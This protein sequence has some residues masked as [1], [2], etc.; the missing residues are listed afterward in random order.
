MPRRAAPRALALAA[1][2]AA[3]ALA[4]PRAADAQAPAPG[5]PPGAGAAPAPGAPPA[6][7]APLVRA[8]QAIPAF[9][10]LRSCLPFN[11]LLAAAAEGGA[12]A[13]D[14]Q[15]QPGGGGGRLI[16]EGDA[17]A[18]NSTRAAVEDG[19][20]TLSLAGGFESR[21]P[22]KI[23]AVMPA[24]AR[25]A[26]A[27]RRCCAPRPR[28]ALRP[29]TARPAPPARRAAGAQLRYAANYGS[30]LLVIGPGHNTSFVRLVA[31]TVGQIQAL[32][33]TA[34]T[35]AFTANGCAA[36]AGA[37]AAAPPL[38]I[39]APARRARSARAAST[40]RA[41]PRPRSVLGS[42]LTG[43]FQRAD[44]TTSVATGSIAFSSATP[45]A[46]SVGLSGITTLVADVPAGSTITGTAGGLSKTPLLFPAPSI[47]GAAGF[48]FAPL[49]GSLLGGKCEAVGARAPAALLEAAGAP[50][51]TCGVIVD[52]AL[53]C[54]GSS[55]SSRQ[56]I[57]WEASNATKALAPNTTAAGAAAAP[58][59]TEQPPGPAVEQLPGASSAPPGGAAGI[60]AGEPALGTSAAGATPTGAAP[61]GAP[62]GAATPVP[63]PAPAGGRRLLQSPVTTPVASIFNPVFVPS[64]PAQDFAA[65]AGGPSPSPS[66]SPG[67]SPSPAPG[68]S[69]SPLPSPSPSPAP[70]GGSAGPSPSP[71]PAPSPA[72]VSVSIRTAGPGGA[73]AGVA[74]VHTVCSAD[75]SALAMLA[76]A[77]PGGAAAAAGNATAAAANAG[78]AAANAANVGAADLG[79]A[80][81][82]AGNAGAAAAGNASV[83]A[84]GSAPAPAPARGAPLARRGADLR[85][86]G[87]WIVPPSAAPGE[88]GAQAGGGTMSAAP[89]GKRR[90]GPTAG[91]HAAAAAAVGGEAPAGAE[92]A[93]SLLPELPEPLVLHVLSFLPP[94]LRAWAAKLVCKA[95][96]ERFRGAEVISLRCPDLPLAAVQE[97][98][99]AV[100]DDERRQWRLKGARTACG[101]V[102]GL[103]WLRRAGC[104]LRGVCW[105]AAEH[106]QVVVLEW[107][108]GEGLDLWGV[109]DAAARTGHIAVLQWARDQGLD[110]EGVCEEA[111]SGGQ[112]AVLRWARADAAAA[113]GPGGAARPARALAQ[114]S[115]CP[116]DNCAPEASACLFSRSRG[117]RCLN[118]AAGFARFRDGRACVCAPGRYR[119][120]GGCMPCPRNSWCPINSRPV[121]CGGALVT[122]REGAASRRLCANPP[123]Y[124]YVP[125]TTDPGV[126]PCGPNTYSAGFGW[127]TQCTPCPSGMETDPAN[128]AGTHTNSSVCLAPP[129]FVL[130]D[131][132]VV[133]C[134]RGSW[135]SGWTGSGA[136]CARC[137]A[138]SPGLTTASVGATSAADCT[139]VEPG[140]AAVSDRGVVMLEGGGPGDA[141][142]A[143]RPC[144]QGYVCA[145]G[146][147]FAGGAG[148][149]QRCPTLGD[150]PGLVT[151]A[152]GATSAEQ[153]VAPPG[154]YVAG[155]G[156][157]AA[158]R[159]VECPDGWFS[160]AWG[161]PSACTPCGANPVEQPSPGAAL[162]GV[163]LP[164][165][166]DGWRS[167][168]TVGVALL[169]P[170]TG[171]VARTL[172]VR[173]SSDSCYLRRGMGSQL[174][175]GDSSDAQQAAPRLVAMFCPTGDAFYGLP[176]DRYGA[177]VRPCQ[178][179]P[180]NLVTRCDGVADV[181]WW[182]P[183]AGA[184]C[185]AALG[186]VAVRDAG[187][188]LKAYAGDAACVLQPGWG[189]ANVTLAP[190][191]GGAA[192]T[193]RAVP[194]PCPPD[195]FSPGGTPDAACRPCGSVLAIYNTTRGATGQTV[196]TT[197]ADP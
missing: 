115:W 91:A 121:P 177:A 50:R 76:A 88:P 97:A 155:D 71:S 105:Q 28:A 108:R 102:A 168:R 56:E 151:A 163:P 93:P 65:D 11:V 24:G 188:A 111:A 32:N 119:A 80:T 61:A 179:C 178:T 150:G 54:Q 84:R 165:D 9:T 167:N 136:E 181:P 197:A 25:A 96:R 6:P 133:P 169:D 175:P 74:V 142:A 12:G 190:G 180:P 47:F 144:P 94:A 58:N 92:A 149:P 72:P 20:L 89:A 17:A 120:T 114:S 63:A 42:V 75:A 104:D 8:D 62:P 60:A 158:P 31:P 95:A 3:L 148:V 15:Q 83:P 192:A 191:G 26:A 1:A 100:Q 156:V 41:A 118:C 90:A 45:V 51:W 147:P 52:G 85:T 37:A 131:G 16:F 173:G 70:A 135:S 79:N 116:V 132:G 139:H 87:D 140:F 98:W 103:A 164:G 193:T 57:S 195:T 34:A 21:A 176:A 153:C 126:E 182:G 43:A 46:L 27:R 44:I 13:A 154:F 112:L 161:R 4:L 174:R 36:A 99:P 109:C 69:A 48:G 7:P 122:A 5:G 19:T 130:Q 183:T 86:P 170:H 66:P 81:A 49:P 137:A 53:S 68:P 138:T 166:G 171:R 123:G 128:V 59:A 160:D 35:L 124:R 107:A 40:R 127:Q 67:P 189:W 159:V 2:L 125:S 157:S 113:L 110:L 141:V 10:G 14:A 143:A 77:A 30:G 184:D 22:I 33:L 129:G 73:A 106:G 134:P 39:T 29:P 187:G 152:E 78:G 196:C 186:A 145:G 18:L 38:A 146:S 23:I 185:A 117:W 82:A 194:G 101:D 162:G 55:P 172:L 64:T